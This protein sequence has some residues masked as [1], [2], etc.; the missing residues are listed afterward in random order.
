MRHVW[1]LI[2]VIE[3]ARDGVADMRQVMQAQD[4]SED[5][6]NE[7]FRG[8]E[9]VIDMIEHELNNPDLAEEEK[10]EEQAEHRWHPTLGWRDST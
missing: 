2:V 6:I 10:Q 3:S 5:E 1:V 9:S 4:K 7:R 8:I